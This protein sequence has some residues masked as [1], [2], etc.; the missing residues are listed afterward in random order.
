MRHHRC[1]GPARWGYEG[2]AC[3][4]LSALL[5]DSTPAGPRRPPSAAFFEPA[6][7]AERYLWGRLDAAERLVRILVTSDDE[8]LVKKYR[9]PLAIRRAFRAQTGPSALALSRLDQTGSGRSSPHG[10]GA[11]T[12]PS[13][14][15]AAG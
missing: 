13:R 14:E 11:V 8:E 6:W 12:V 7:P 2:D 9:E 4:A 5:R 3:D 15:D 10:I 1:L